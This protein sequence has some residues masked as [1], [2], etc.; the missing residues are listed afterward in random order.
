M[1]DEPLLEASSAALA[2]ES[3]ADMS[4]RVADILATL[5]TARGT[6]PETGA[7]PG[8]IAAVVI[9]DQIERAVRQYR[10]AK[11]TDSLE[12]YLDGYGFAKTAR[13]L[14]TEHSAEIS[15]ISEDLSGA[16]AAAISSLETAYPTAMRPE[17]LDARVGQMTAQSSE[18]QLLLSSL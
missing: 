13:A 12:P 14:Y 6:A 8:Q 2:Q 10:S 15:G 11:Q 3:S 9:A 7:T 18:V 16:M 4:A 5:K 17:T 1:L